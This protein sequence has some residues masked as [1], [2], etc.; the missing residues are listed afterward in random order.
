MVSRKRK[1]KGKILF[2]A[3]HAKREV[4]SG[5]K[6]FRPSK[7]RKKVSVNLAPLA[8]E[9]TRARGFDRDSMESNWRVGVIA[10]AIYESTDL[11]WQDMVDQVNAMLD[12]DMSKEWLTQ[13]TRTAKKI[14]RTIEEYREFLARHSDVSD[15]TSLMR[16]VGTRPKRQPSYDTRT[17][18][19][20]SIPTEI[21]EA[22]RTLNFD[23]REAIRD[24]VHLTS[25]IPRWRKVIAAAGLEPTHYEH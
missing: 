2:Y 10:L 12:Q 8:A 22:A 7:G 4:L 17:D 1:E 9:I 21:G 14:G 20:V 11:T 18:F 25:S 5:E 3:E 23:L 13:R 15:W 6:V 24:L 16:A 19:R